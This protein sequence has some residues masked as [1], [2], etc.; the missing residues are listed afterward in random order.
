MSHKTIEIT[1]GDFG[2]YIKKF[3]RQNAIDKIV[4]FSGGSDKKEEDVRNIIEDTIHILKN[5]PVAIL[6]GA[7]KFG[8]P[9]FA[10]QCAKDNGMRVI[11]I[12]PLA[13]KKHAL[14]SH[15]FDLQIN[16]SPSYANMAGNSTPRLRDFTTND[17]SQS[18]WGDESPLF[19]KLADAMVVIGGGS[20]TL[21]EV[22]HA[23]KIN[24]ELIKPD[25]H[26][27]PIYIVPVLGV[28]GVSEVI[29]FLP[30][31]EE[32][33]RKVLP[34]N[35]RIFT[36]K[37]V[38]TFLIE[39]LNIIP[40]Y[41]ESAQ[42]DLE[43]QE[44]NVQSKENDLIEAKTLS[45]FRDI[46]P[47]LAIVKEDMLNEIKKV[48]RSFGFSPI[49]T[50]HI[51]YSEVL[52]GK[53][54]DEI[55]KQLYRFEDNGKRDVTLRFDHTVPLAR[56]VVQHKN[57][58]GLPFKRYAV[59]NVFRGESPQSGRYREFTQCDF[60]F[61]GTYSTAADAEIVQVIYHSLK[62]IKLDE[63]TIFLNNRKIMDG[64][65][66][67]INASEK[68][69][70]IL[71]TVDKINKIGSDKIKELLLSEIGLTEQD[72][73]EIMD[74]I[75]IN[76]REVTGNFFE[77]IEKYKSYNETMKQGIEELEFL[78]QVLDKAG[79]DKNNYAIDFSVARGLAYYTG[80]VY[81]TTLDKLPKIGAIASGGRFD[82]LTKSFSTDNLPGVGASIGID[83]LIAALEQ[84][85]IIKSKNTPAKVLIAN[86][87]KNYLADSYCL[88]KQ[89]RDANIA[90][91]VYPEVAKISKQFNFAQKKGHKFV[92]GFGETEAT[93]NEYILANIE[94][95]DKITAK[96]IEEL[97]KLIK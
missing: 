39:K 87:D 63:F 71:R 1:I 28:S 58:L 44:T 19:A 60:D 47:S 48:F 22:A 10:T 51:E 74:F 46:L 41:Y 17:Y 30:F 40:N 89:L 3:K 14:P 9:E 93:K 70:D 36:G 95:G 57:E 81:E 50:P 25:S 4:A 67:K 52:L 80:I 65:A 27:R 33:K 72:A 29:N 31:K 12:I 45:G 59:G 6:T 16:V 37:Q 53:G 69:G 23:M 18:F 75:L 77:Y 86:L 32:V 90:V 15:Y 61:I 56:F 78:Y 11:G 92:I 94:T 73:V 85:D 91:E 24:E 13:G 42:K 5:F 20:G 83:R 84:L 96:S 64:L 54:S 8:V 26:R 55:Q 35:E 62:S 7:T 38:A 76:E 82:N 66:E 97:I 79:V 21:I 88:A 34:D 68:V 43:M 2:S 49:E